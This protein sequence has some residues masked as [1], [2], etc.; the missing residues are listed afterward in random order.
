MNLEDYQSY[1]AYQ[2][3]R[4]PWRV[5]DMIGSTALWVGNLF[6]AQPLLPVSTMNLIR[7]YSW[8]VPPANWTSQHLMISNP[9][10]PAIA[11]VDATL[12]GADEYS[13]EQYLRDLQNAA[14]TERDYWQQAYESLVPAFK[15]VTAA[16]RVG[17]VVGRSLLSAVGGSSKTG[18]KTFS[19]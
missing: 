11:G 18:S 10:Y 14:W 8:L 19:K 13:Y 4:N 2:V 12:L 15:N 6:V 3:G 9:V 5:L 7:S 1:L 17:T 16:R